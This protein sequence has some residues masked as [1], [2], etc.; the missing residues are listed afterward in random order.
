MK[1]AGKPHPDILYSSKLLVAW[2][3]HLKLQ[4]RRPA[5]IADYSGAVENWFKWAATNGVAIP[6][7]VSP[8][9][10]SAWL[11]WAYGHYGSA[12][13][14]RNRYM[15]VR[16]FYDWLVEVEEEIPVSPFGSRM[17]RK[18]K[19][20]ELEETAKDVVTTEEMDRAFAMLEKGK[21]YRDAALLAVLYDTGMRAGEL[22]NLPM[23]AYDP[24]TGVI[25]IER[26]KGKRIRYVRLSPEAL[27]HVER[28]LRRRND[29]N[30]YFINGTTSRGKMTPSG[31]YGAV[32]K[33]FED[34]G[35]K[36]TIGAHDIRH[37]SATHVA[38]SGLMSESDAMELYGWKEPEM[39]RHYTQQ[40]R[41]DAALAAH[42]AASPMARLAKLKQQKK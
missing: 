31:V 33:I 15:G 24:L 19:P 20:P 12:A 1:K 14:V 35:L 4:N 30:P 9:D 36:R 41:K 34:L 17:A 27:R 2:Q 39:W 16:H 32:R 38:M 22:A 37:T 18:I 6:L 7:D 11:E 10:V 21:R 8:S 40:A 5:T 23:S 42:E 3:R 26:T 28:Y 29:E 13:S 25:T